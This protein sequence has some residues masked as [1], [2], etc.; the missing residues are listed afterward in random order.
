MTTEVLAGERTRVSRG[1]IGSY[2]LMYLGVNIAWAAPSQL[3]IANQLL[4]MHPDEKEARLAIVM[5]VGGLLGLLAGPLIGL[6]SDRTRSPIGRRA[7]W[8]IGGAIGAAAMLVALA[9]STSFGMLVALWGLFQILIAAPVNASQAIPP[10]RVPQKQYGTVSAVMG[11]GWT[12]AVVVGTVLGEGLPLVGAYV[13]S[14]GLLLALTVPYL[15]RFARRDAAKAQLSE[16][17]SLL[18]VTAGEAGFEP[19]PAEPVDAGPGRYRDFTWV[20]IS[21][22]AATL[23]NTV[24]LFYLLYY[25]RD[26]IGLD[27]PDLGVLILTVVYA[28]VTVVAAIVSGQLSDR[29]GAR[30]PFVVIGCL[31]VALACATMAFV[32]S[33]AMVVL[34]AVI[35]GAAWGTFTAIDQ[36]L[37]NQVLPNP[38]RRGR[39]IG[40]MALAV[41]TPNLLAPLLA[42]FALLSLGGYPGLYVMSAALAVVGAVTVLLVRGSR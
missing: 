3:L 39:D 4:I 21:R 33:F 36:A 9:F 27:D 5:A 15:I 1:W 31:G 6:L 28:L 19:L 41:L 42:A 35:L 26:H 23:G 22:L 13:A 34:A 8:I 32:H 2:G 38:E 10:D 16:P 29:L 18:A 37:V 24:A 12:M 17:R 25:L 14:A 7:P 30:K 11:I 40:I 20:F